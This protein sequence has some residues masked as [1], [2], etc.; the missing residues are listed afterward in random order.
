MTKSQP[1]IRK[2]FWKRKPF[3]FV[4]VPLSI[5]MLVVL[6]Y[7]GM[8][9]Q[10][11]RRV[12]AEVQRIRLSNLPV[13]SETQSQW[14]LANSSK[15]HSDAWAEI[16]MLG[17]AVANEREVLDNLPYIGNADIPPVIDPGNPWPNEPVVAQWLEVTKPLIDKIHSV[18][19]LKKPTWQ[20]LDF[21]GFMTLLE[22][23]QNSRNLARILQVEVEH[24]LYVG[25]AERA[26]R[27]LQ[28]LD[29]I[30]HAFDWN[31]CLV[32]DLVGI[33]LRGVHFSMIQRSLSLDI[34]TDEQLAELSS[35]VAQRQDVNE[36]WR[37]TIAGERGLML[38]AVTNQ[39]PGF[40]ESVGGMGFLFSIPSVQESLLTVY[41][42]IESAADQGIDELAKN[43]KE[44]EK[45]PPFTDDDRFSIEG[46]GARMIVPAVQAFA[47]AV[48]RN[49]D[50]RRFTST[51][52]GIKRFQLANGQFPASLDQLKAIGMNPSD[53]MTVGG[54]VFGYTSGDV[55]YVWS[56]SFRD[57]QTI[58]PEKPEEDENGMEQIV[59]IR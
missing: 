28:S 6:Y 12:A 55:A 45:H 40:G 2:S 16:L 8:Q 27:G 23:I 37:A 19:R 14:F 43:A 33:A 25:D 42:R 32:T 52:I 39:G 3:L 31:I 47:D 58:A 29:G 17:A 20:P 57:P 36:R 11:S 10:A 4:A 35:Q 21:Q 26:M 5:A 15:E 1:S 59:T 48:I 54:K 22:P 7:A 56:Y 24:A 53:W 50:M 38:D 51:A 44:I 41:S 46:L 18:G 9:Y 13:D 49:E 34:W 30:A